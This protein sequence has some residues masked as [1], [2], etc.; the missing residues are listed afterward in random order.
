MFKGFGKQKEP[1]IK[2]V[3]NE[4][5]KQYAF[6]KDFCSQEREC[7]VLL[8][9]IVMKFFND[10]EDAGHSES[11]RM[12][13]ARILAGT[14]VNTASQ[15]WDPE[16]DTDMRDVLRFTLEATEEQLLEIPA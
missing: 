3:I 15:R 1:S 7:E 8:A 4:S 12:Q 6:L 5:L 9:Q 14:A 13:Y 10:Q 11:T 2:E 16:L